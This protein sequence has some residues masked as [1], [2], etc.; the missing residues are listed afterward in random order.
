MRNE[1]TKASDNVP[2]SVGQERKTPSRSN[3][4]VQGHDSGKERDERR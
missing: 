2:S 1:D 4:D 3:A